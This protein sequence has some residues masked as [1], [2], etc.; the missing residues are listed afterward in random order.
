MSKISWFLILFCPF[1]VFGQ[2]E[3]KVNGKNFNIR[4]SVVKEKYIKL[5]NTCY[6]P[7][8]KFKENEKVASVGA[9]WGIKEIIYSL[10]SP[11]I[12]FYL[13]D[14]D[15][16]FLNPDLLSQELLLFQKKYK[17]QTKSEFRIYIGDSVSTN[18][19]QILFD[20]I[21]IEN[22]LHE[23]SNPNEML[24]DIEQKLSIDGRLFISEQIVNR[25]NKKHKGCKKPIFV[26]SGLLSL[27]IKHHFVLSK[28]HQ[29]YP[30]KDDFF[31]FEFR[32]N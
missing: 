20:K 4:N 30:K 16:R 29:P 27:L 13:E 12:Y 18:L 21:L 1:Q 23:F 24:A 26:E 11:K 14:I 8:Y 32:K 3:L 2:Y 10:E 28:K 6:Q 9:G 31:V 7:I 25:P 19:P 15:P 17:K 22:S 5:E